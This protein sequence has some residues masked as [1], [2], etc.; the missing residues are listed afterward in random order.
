M[1]CC[2]IVRSMHQDALNC[3]SYQEMIKKNKM[4]KK[5]PPL[6]MKKKK[7]GLIPP[8]ISMPCWMCECRSIMWSAPR[9]LKPFATRDEQ[10]N[11]PPPSPV[12]PLLLRDD[13]DA[14]DRLEPEARRPQ[15]HSRGLLLFI[16]QLAHRADTCSLPLRTG[17]L[18]GGWLLG[19]RQ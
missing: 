6:M 12:L 17:F 15:G 4:L 16:H 3:T 19:R 9:N 14:S 10:S 13:A 5:N 11:T 2:R 1:K 7:G 18:T 8:L